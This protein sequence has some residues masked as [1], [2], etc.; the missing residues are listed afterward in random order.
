MFQN[1]II[2]FNF[3]AY[4][5]VAIKSINIVKFTSKVFNKMFCNFVENIQNYF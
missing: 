1:Y 4:Q 3:H 5:N 2:I